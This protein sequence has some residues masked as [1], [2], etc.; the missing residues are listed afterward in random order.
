M[1]HWF[2]W[3]VGAGLA[4]LL[5]YADLVYQLI[6]LLH[7]PPLWA[8]LTVFFA[9][10]VVVGIADWIKTDDGFEAFMSGCE[11]FFRPSLLLLSFMEPSEERFS[12]TDWKES[13]G[14]LAISFCYTGT[15]CAAVIFT[16]WPWYADLGVAFAVLVT[17]VLVAGALPRL[18]GLRSQLE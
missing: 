17:Q 5:V 9:V 8:A 11:A 1:R 10:P 7:M 14:N 16:N 13:S 15:F 3:L 18:K 6:W 4:M 2:S 12:A